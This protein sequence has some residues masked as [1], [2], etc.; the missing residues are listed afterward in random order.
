MDN[1]Q[2]VWNGNTEMQNDNVK[3]LNLLQRFFG[4]IFSPSETMKCIVE[5]PKVLFPILAMAITPVLVNIIRLPLYKEMQR[6][7]M[8]KTSE[9]MAARFNTPVMTAADIDKAVS[10][11]LIFGSIT[12]P[13]V[14][15]IMWL[16][17]TAVIFGILK[18]FGGQGKF[19]QC[20][21]VTGYAS[22]I[23]V[24]LSVLTL[25]VSFFS[26]SLKLDL[27]LGIFAGQLLSG[28]EGSFIY[29][30]MYTLLTA[31]GVFTIWNYAVTGLGLIHMTKL[32]KAKVC[33]VIIVYFIVVVLLGGALAGVT[34]VMT[35]G[36]S[37]QI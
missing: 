23:T 18:A 37:S 14:T 9:T 5:R 25:I 35:S 7:L 28:S 2:P 36:I 6:E 30:L 32:S 11:N 26:G 24:L 16:I 13:I 22:M 31:I 34:E 29:G 1:L 20:M 12:T 3:N 33:A 19:K 27:S 21:A 10:N 4:V 8:V 17:G 15:I